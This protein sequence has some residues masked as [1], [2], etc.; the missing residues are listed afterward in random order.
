MNFKNLL[1]A[2]LFCISAVSC[3]NSDVINDIKTNNDGQAISFNIDFAPTKDHT[4]TL[5]Q[6]GNNG[7]TEQALSISKLEVRLEAKEGATNWTTLYDKTSSAINNESFKFDEAGKVVTIFGVKDPSK[8][9]VRI[10]HLETTAGNSYTNVKNFQVA[11]SADVPAYGATNQFAA[12]SGVTKD[13]NGKKY[14]VIKTR[15]NVNIPVARIELSNFH[16][17]KNDVFA[18]LDLERIFINNTYSTLGVSDI[19]SSFAYS[20]LLTKNAFSEDLLSDVVNQSILSEIKE[21]YAYSIFPTTN[22]EDFAKVTLQFNNTELKNTNVNFDSKAPR[23]AVI[24]KM[25]NNENFTFEAGKIYR[26]KKMH[27]TDDNIG[28]DINGNNLQAIEVELEVQ[29][30]N[31]IDIADITWN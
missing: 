9:Q 26:I 18:A 29:S 22:K 28:V 1:T 31:Y 27:L 12:N 13:L 14:E 11:K 21:T 8:L 10:N 30:W 20:N 24:T 3:N 6:D 5:S 19:N 15:V 25:N 16:L 23:Y 4:R 17:T 7:Q 2:T